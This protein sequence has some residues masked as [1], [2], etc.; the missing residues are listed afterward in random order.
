[1][2]PKC[3]KQKAMH[4][5]FCGYCGA[6]LSVNGNS[7]D[8]AMQYDVKKPGKQP[9]HK[10]NVGKPVLLVVLC[11]I[12][13]LIVIVVITDEEKPKTNDASP[14][15]QHRILTAEEIAALGRASTVQIEGRFVEK[16]LIFS[17]DKYTWTGSGVIID[18]EA[19]K[20]FILTN[21]HVTGFIDMYNADS[22]PE[23]S[24]YAINVTMPDGKNCFAERILI[25]YDFKDFALLIVDGG[26]SSYPVLRLSDVI[27]S[28]GAKVYAMGHPRGLSYSFTSGIL[29]AVRN[30][31]RNGEVI[32]IDAAI[33]PGNS[34]GP[35]ID[36]KGRLIGINT[37]K[38]NN[39]ESLNF[40]ISSREVLRGFNSN[41][42]R[43]IPTNPAELTQL[44]KKI[45][46]K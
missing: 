26:G 29:S 5:K 7:Q 35:L 31:D 23:I 9:L 1:M 36:E 17:D 43:E 28:Q 30:H 24:Q 3:E 18:K 20:Y 19:N 2:C 34:G 38:Q 22:R 4:N 33:N 45:K 42:M 44:F 14:Q 21:E 10:K 6:D 13:A 46:S 27:P 16:N 40:A 11:A 41:K 25:N 15:N 37:F 12:I 32:Q 8:S 39:S